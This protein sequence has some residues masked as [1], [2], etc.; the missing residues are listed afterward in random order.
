[1]KKVG[2]VSLL[3]KLMLNEFHFCKQYCQIFIMDKIFKKSVNI[4]SPSLSSSRIVGE[5]F[6]N[7]MSIFTKGNS[8]QNENHKF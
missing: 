3:F 8:C 5:A 7:S 6:L 1:M 2:G 4:K